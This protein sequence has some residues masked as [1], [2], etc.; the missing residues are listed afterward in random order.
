MLGCRRIVR[1]RRR[2]L[3]LPGCA[4]SDL[5]HHGADGARVRARR[6]SALGSRALMQ[7]IGL[8]E[9]LAVGA[10]IAR[11]QTNRYGGDAQGQTDRFE[12]RLA[13]LIG[14]PHALTV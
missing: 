5:D 12:A 8:R 13:A 2:G 7:N 1:H 6:K 9:W 3:S 11:G 10:V 4:K 14:V